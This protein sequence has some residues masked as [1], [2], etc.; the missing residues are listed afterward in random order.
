MSSISRNLAHTTSNQETLSAFINSKVSNMLQGPK[1]DT[2][3]TSVVS[4]VTNN[5][6]LAECNRGTIVSSALQ[7]AALDLSPSP[8]LGHFY[9][10][11]FK[12]RKNDRVVAQFQIG[13]KGYIQ[14]AIRSGQYRRINVMEIR[15]GELN[16][17]NPMS[18][19]ISVQIIENDDVRTKLP[20][21]GYYAMFELTNGFQKAVYWSK[22]K[23]E[24]H[25]I[26]YSQGYKAKK[27][28]TFWERDFDA[29]AFKTMLRHLLSKWGVMSIELQNAIDKDM[30]IVDGDGRIYHED[31]DLIDVPISGV[32]TIKTDKEDAPSP[33]SGNL[34]SNEKSDASD[35][36]NAFFGEDKPHVPTFAQVNDRMV[37]AKTI[38]ELHDA[39]DEIRFV[40]D[41]QHQDELHKV[42]EGQR[43]KFEK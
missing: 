17:W 22:E 14:L 33:D 25:A 29:M 43:A 13:Y 11:P 12:D 19:Q 21:V 6:A 23:M 31:N 18:E 40:A 10:V 3:V 42:Y 1:R 39:A 32:N 16:G 24:S 27:G 2:F 36:V 34:S 35:P 37:K 26:T 28:Y 8:I 38:D 41:K 4:A 30:G 15:E 20:V 9:M 5:P 7:G